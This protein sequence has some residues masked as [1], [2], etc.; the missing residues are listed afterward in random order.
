[1]TEGQPPA[2]ITEED[3]EGVL[4]GLAATAHTL[5]CWV[6]EARPLVERLAEDYPAAAVLVESLTVAEARPAHLGTPRH[7][8]EETIQILHGLRT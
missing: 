1:L 8:E 2:A 4:G 6:R 7:L 3:I 5:R